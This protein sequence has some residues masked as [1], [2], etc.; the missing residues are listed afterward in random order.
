MRVPILVK[1]LP[2]LFRSPNWKQRYAALQTMCIMGE[3]INEQVCDDLEGFVKMMVPFISDEHPRVR[4]ASLNT[5]VRET[6]RF[7]GDRDMESCF[8]AKLLRRLLQAVYLIVGYLVIA[9][10]VTSVFY[11]DPAIVLISV[12]ASAAVIF[13][14]WK[15]ISELS[16]SIPEASEKGRKSKA[17]SEN[18]LLIELMMR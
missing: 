9:S 8:A 2:T 15:G 5:L 10:S 12:A 16:I 7:F 1:V 6:E 14:L 18:D 13:L 4:F 3:G 11:F 17:K